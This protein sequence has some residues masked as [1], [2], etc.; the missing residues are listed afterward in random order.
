MSFRKNKE[1]VLDI[2]CVIVPEYFCDST[3]WRLALHLTQVEPWINL[4]LLNA[5]PH[6]ASTAETCFVAALAIVA[7]TP[8]I[9]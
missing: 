8:E 7:V 3:L 2:N 1:P 5:H 4:R 6:L 9:R